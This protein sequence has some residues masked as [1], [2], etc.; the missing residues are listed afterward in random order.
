MRAGLTFP[1]AIP[2]SSAAICGASV[3]EGPTPTRHSSDCRSTRQHAVPIGSVA[4]AWR[5]AGGP[6]DQEL[7]I[8][9]S[10]PLGLLRVYNGRRVIPRSLRAYL[11]PSLA[12]PCDVGFLPVFKSPRGKTLGCWRETAGPVRTN[13][14]TWAKDGSAV[15]SCSRIMA[16]KILVAVFQPIFGN[17]RPCGD[18]SLFRCDR[19]LAG[20]ARKKLLLTDSLRLRSYEISSV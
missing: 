16:T 15:P 3:A 12:K 5:L 20:D 19:Q 4:G 11:S 18:F 1:K 6:A 10:A 8:D 7:A 2:L 13:P 14:G 17:I 9:H